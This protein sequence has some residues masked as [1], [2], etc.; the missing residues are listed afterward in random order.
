MEATGF[1]ET[2]G[3]YL[4]RH[5][6]SQV[7]VDGKSLGLSVLSQ[8]FGTVLEPSAL[9]YFTKQTQLVG[10]SRCDSYILT[11]DRRHNVVICNVQ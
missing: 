6:P 11:F 8:D 5:I 7:R 4:Q 2:F 3:A 9:A 1:S 10:T